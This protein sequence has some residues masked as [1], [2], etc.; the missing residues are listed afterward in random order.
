MKVIARS[1]VFRYKGREVDVQQAAKD[2]NVRA[3]LT[4]RVIERG[5]TLDVSIDLTDAQTNAQLWGQ[6][7][8]RKAADIFAVQDEIAQQATNALRLRLTGAQAERVVKR[9]TQDEEAYKLYLQ[10]RFYFNKHT[11]DGARKAVDYFKQAIA[12]DPAYALA[13]AGL[14]DAYDEIGGAPGA[15]P[16]EVYSQARAAVTQ[17][18]RLDNNLAEAHEALGIIKWDYDWDARGAESEYKEALALN[19]NNAVAHDSYAMLLLDVGRFDEALA[20][21]KQAQEL[22]PL[23]IYISKHLGTYYLFTHQ[24]DRALA[25]LQKTLELDPNFQMTYMDTGFS[26][27]QKGQYTEALAQFKKMQQLEPENADALAGQGYVYVLLGKDGEARQKIK[28]LKTLS[29]RGCYVALDVA[30]IYGALGDKE[31]MYEWLEKGIQQ[32][33]SNMVNLR[34]HPALEP[35]HSDPRFQDL[36]RRVGLPQ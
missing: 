2:L 32:R 17:A 11:G 5:D 12:R 34:V 20:Q 27:A 35:L 10:G 30:S 24:Y 23:S 25:Q 4:G 33:D 13:Y 26:Y 22:D 9:Y 28:E 15:P 1:S 3:V 19:P 36:L 18:L 29:A 8:T 21:I 16:D 6:H 14:A 7:F 31:H